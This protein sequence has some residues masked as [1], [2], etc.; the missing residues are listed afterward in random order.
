LDQLIKQWEDA[1][2]DQDLARQKLEALKVI[3]L[4]CEFNGFFII[5]IFSLL[6]MEERDLQDQL[7]FLEQEEQALNRELETKVEERR[8]I[9]EKD[10]HLYRKLRDNHRQAFCNAK[11]SNQN[12]Q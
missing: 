10:E 7:A 8:H 2:F 1:P 9:I 5:F 3:I 4:L 6:Q 12:S 11:I